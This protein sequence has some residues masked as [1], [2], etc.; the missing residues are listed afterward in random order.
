MKY[1]LQV[2]RLEILQLLWFLSN[3]QLAHGKGTGKGQ[4]YSKSRKVLP[5][6]YQPGDFAIHVQ[7]SQTSL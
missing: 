6:L 7:Y 2:S 1:R 3:E 5:I 4:T